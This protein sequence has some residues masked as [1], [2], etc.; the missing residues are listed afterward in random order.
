MFYIGI[1]SEIAAADLILP[2]KKPNVSQELK[3]KTAKSKRI[4]PEKKP[5]TKKEEIVSI[6]LKGKSYIAESLVEKVIYSKYVHYQ[7]CHEMDL[8]YLFD[9]YVQYIRVR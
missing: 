1:Y 7:D 9:I 3:T 8:Y 6:N 4:Y 2:V 5:V